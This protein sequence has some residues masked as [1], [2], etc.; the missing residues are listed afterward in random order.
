MLYLIIFILLLVLSYRY[1]YCGKEKGRTVWIWVVLLLF[2]LIAGLRYRIG[3]DSIRYET[4]FTRNCPVIEDLAMHDFQKTRFAPLYIILNSIVRT[5]TDDFMVF[6]FIHATIVCSVMVWFLVHNTRNVFFAFAVFSLFLYL[7]L[8]TEVLRESLAV[9]VF[10][11]AWPFFKEGKW[12]KWY[13]MSVIGVLCHTSA[14]VMVVL[15]LICLPGLRSIFIFGKRTGLICILILLLAI[16]VQ[17]MF[18]RYIQLLAISENVSERAE[19]YSKSHYGT[20]GLN[21]MGML[22]QTIRYVIY[23][24]CALYFL[25]KNK[26]YNKIVGTG[27]FDKLV[28]FS[29]MSVY[30]AIFSMMVPIISRY[31]NYFFPFTIIVLSDFIYCRL[32]VLSREIRFKFIYWILFFLPMFAMQLQLGYLGAVNPSKTLK[33]YMPYY[34]YSSRIEMSKDTDREK[35]YRYQ[36]AW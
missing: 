5:F 18:F 1:D 24:L 12:L 35:W 20:Q 9:S 10:L 32:P 7:L 28:A 22:G 8:L 21:P 6:Q 11:L 14:V 31:M 26:T 27:G 13:A 15:P 2:I 17:I 19:V 25:Y 29:L 16:G 33:A 34:P 30:V 23:P 3:T 4:Y 36:H